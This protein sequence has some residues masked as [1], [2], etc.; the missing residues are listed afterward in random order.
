MLFVI[1]IVESLLK[2]VFY[3]YARK[4]IETSFDYCMQSL[5]QDVSKR[6]KAL[7]IALVLV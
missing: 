4:R 5:I 7:E 6:V 2:V 1:Y 3:K